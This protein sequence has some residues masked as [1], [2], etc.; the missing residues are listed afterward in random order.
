M[1]KILYILLALAPVLLQSQATTGYHRVSQVLARSNSGTY[2]VVQPFSTISVTSTATGLAATIYSDPLLTA[3]ISPSVVT[4]DR[5]GNYD[6]YIALGYCVTETI[7]YPGSGGTVIPNVCVVSGT[8]T[9]QINNGTTGQLAYY[10]SSGNVLSGETFATLAQG[11]TGATTASG[12]WTNISAGVGTQAANKVWAGPTTGAA[13]LP[14]F[15]LL[16][17]ADIPN[18]AADTSGNA[19]TATIATTAATATA[20]A[21]S[22]TQCAGTQFA[23]GITT[24]GNANC[25]SPSVGIT[26]LSGDATAGPGGGNQTLTFATVNSGPGTCGDA[27][28]VCQVVTNGK[29]LVTSQTSVPI[30]IFTSGSNANG[31]WVTDPT[32]TI[33]ER[34]A[35]TVT[36]GG[37]TLVTGTI[38][39][40]LTFPTALDSLV[41]SAG[42]NPGG[43]DDAFTV[44]YRGFS[45]S[46]ATVVARCAVNI[47]G[48]GC[49]SISNTVPITW[50]AIGR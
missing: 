1:K 8:T 36:N 47:G 31:R 35:I 43:S 42:N 15:R 45:S 21:G 3:P 26:Q 32:G 24:T 13:T 40:P 20:L 50:I 5:S 33:T 30:S 23:Q 25:A 16:V 11:G 49:A 48:S 18:N 14:T 29:G 28:H 7:A 46:G 9:G 39:F 34:G 6:Y 38:T 22:P 19:A 17:S 44:Y 27:S 12:A 4:A 37:G 2:A 10:A 41:V